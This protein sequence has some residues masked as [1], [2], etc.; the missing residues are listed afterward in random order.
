MSMS[1]VPGSIST[2]DVLLS[3]NDAPMMFV[4][5]ALIQSAAGYARSKVTVARAAFVNANW[6]LWTSVG[7]AEFVKTIWPP[8]VNELGPACVRPL[9]IANASE[10]S[11]EP[12]AGSETVAGDGVTFD[13]NAT[14]DLIV[15][16]T[17]CAPRFV[18]CSVLVAVQLF[19][20]IGARPRLTDGG[21]ITVLPV[22]AA[23]ASMRPAPSF[24]MSVCRRVALFINASLIC[25]GVQS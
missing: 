1:Q 19:V 4:R 18:R 24:M 15:Y 14:F 3:R 21:S 10:T 9:S 7:D 23:Y 17:A 20:S 12:P 13:P 8:L 22:A 6:T 2:S 25:A 16:V 11:A 5:A